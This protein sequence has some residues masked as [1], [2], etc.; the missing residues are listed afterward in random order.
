VYYGSVRPDPMGDG[1]HLWAVADPAAG[2]GGAVP[3]AVAEWLIDN[4][5]LGGTDA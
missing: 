5:V 1:V 2:A 3:V 4:G